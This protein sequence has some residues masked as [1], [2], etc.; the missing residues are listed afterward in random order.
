MAMGTF[1]SSSIDSVTALTDIDRL[2]VGDFNRDG[3]LDLAQATSAGVLIALGKGDGTFGS[4]TQVGSFVPGGSYNDILAADLDGDG[5]SDLV[6]S[7][8]AAKNI[9]VLLGHGDGSFR[10]KETIST[11][12]NSVAVADF[13]GDHRPDLAYISTESGTF[14]ASVRL[15]NGDGTLGAFVGLASAAFAVTVADVNGDGKP[16]LI[17]SGVQCSSSS[18][19]IGEHLGVH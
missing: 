6:A 13:N 7:S 8:P 5:A 16:D 12:A 17:A 18:R 11:D 19:Y 1:K 15:K 9:A 14:A 10:L 3:K 2:A 4:A